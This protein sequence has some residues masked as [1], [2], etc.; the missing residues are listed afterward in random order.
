MSIEKGP[1]ALP[2]EYTCSGCPC[3]KTEWWKDYLDNDETDSGTTATCTEV[4]KVITAYWNE[5]YSIPAF[6]PF[7]K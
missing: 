5:R 7:K 3:L 2:T 6:C 1:R 4:G